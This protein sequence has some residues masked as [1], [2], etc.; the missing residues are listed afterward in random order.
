MSQATRT[1]ERD[2]PK[3]T[4]RA[5]VLLVTMTLLVLLALAPARQF[6][7]QRGQIADLQRRTAELQL[8]NARLQDR[9]DRLD[10]P[11]ELERLAR[12]CLGMVAPGEVAL[13]VPGSRAE[14]GDC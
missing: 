1:L 6:L 2:G 13:V 9:I 7:D 8:T 10:D 12:E 4:A 14:R 11:A 5:A 3:L